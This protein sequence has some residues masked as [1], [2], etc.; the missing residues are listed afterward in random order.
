MPYTHAGATSIVCA[1]YRITTVYVAYSD[2]IV[3]EGMH[4][5]NIILKLHI[6]SLWGLR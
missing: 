4:I 1:L 3:V 5:M 6:K 2:P